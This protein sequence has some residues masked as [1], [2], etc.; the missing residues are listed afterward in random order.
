MFDVI[1]LMRLKLITLGSERVYQAFS[2]VDALDDDLL[3]SSP[4]G[5]MAFSRSENVTVSL[6]ERDSHIL[7]LFLRGSLRTNVNFR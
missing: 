5:C 6:A 3:T 7:G 4:C 1:F 2:T